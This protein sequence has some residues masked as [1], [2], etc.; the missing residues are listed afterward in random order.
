[1]AINDRDAEAL[2]S[3]T[4]IEL[5]W[6]ENMTDFTVKFYFEENVFFKN[7]VLEKKFHHDKESEAIKGD[8]T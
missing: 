4:N 8:G 5:V 3:L 2:K 1:L 6:D 7:A